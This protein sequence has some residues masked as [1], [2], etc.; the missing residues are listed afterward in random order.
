MTTRHIFISGPAQSGRTTAAIA[1]ANA[2][3]D[4]GICT[5]FVSPCPMMADF[6]RSSARRPRCRIT[7]ASPNALPAIPA[8]CFVV[9]D[10]ERLEAPGDIVRVLIHRQMTYRLPVIV[11]AVRQDALD[12]FQELIAEVDPEG[13][14]V[15]ERRLEQAL[16]AIASRD[17]SALTYQDLQLTG[18]AASDS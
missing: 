18:S 10:A 17:F 15:D 3:H 13:F 14:G 6:L 8:G 9:D 11:W 5:T 1:M 4:Q 2:M 16:A 12:R 7:H